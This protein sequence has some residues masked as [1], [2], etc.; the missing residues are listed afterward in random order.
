MLPRVQLA[1][2]AV[3][4]AARLSA[5]CSGEEGGAAL[6]SGPAPST[7]AAPRDAGSP[8]DAGTEA[9]RDAGPLGDAGT[10]LPGDAGPPAHLDA[11]TSPDASAPPDASV[12]PIDETGP[13][14]RLEGRAG[15]LAGFALD[16]VEVDA[17]GNL[18]LG[19]GHPATDPYGP[20]GYEGG[21]YYN[22]GAYR[23][24]VAVSPI[25]EPAAA[26]DEVVPSFDAWTPEGT[27][28]TVKVRARVSGRWTR[29]YVLAVWAFE[30]GTVERHS[31]DGQDDADGR[32]STDTL[33]L[34]APADALQVIVVLCS[35]VGG[36]T[37]V[38][39][40]LAASAFDTTR[41]PRPDPGDPS[42]WGTVL[43]VPGRS[44]MI[45]PDGGEVWCSPTSTSMLLAYWAD[46]LQEPALRQTVPATAALTFD[47]IYGGNGN[48]PFNT[49]HAVAAAGGRLQGFVTRL[50]SFAQLE[51][52][53]AAEVPVAIS[54]S[55]G[56]GELGGS[57][58]R[59]TAGHLIVI[60]GFTANGDVVSNDPAFGADDAVEVS[61]DRAELDRAWVHS[62]RTAYVVYPDER[63]LPA[64]PL[65]AY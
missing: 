11:S 25:L 42:V 29:D 4:A 41:A 22:G 27:W 7:D 18:I 48:W 8:L 46:V 10:M 17:D 49:A 47:W 35:E 53:I 61:Y 23:Y 33:A 26:F 60:K 34:A 24:G 44:Q 39:R 45:Y 15:H 30:S 37:P 64:D 16:E 13:L 12:S 65:G 50:D 14:I 3:F 9:P 38:V 5:G 43:P 62:S 40:A 36:V 32:V 21:N 31:V 1:L 28:I 54:V 2:L 19:T 52:L 20:G 57:P 58:I 6:D 59:S 55:Y 51:R 63:T 56:A